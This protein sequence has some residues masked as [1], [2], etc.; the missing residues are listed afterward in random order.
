[1]IGYGPPGDWGQLPTHGD[2]DHERRAAEEYAGRRRVR[3]RMGLVA[4]VVIVIAAT[5]VV[6]LLVTHP[7]RHG[8]LIYRIEPSKG[9]LK[10]ALTDDRSGKHT[11]WVTLRNARGKLMRYG[12]TAFRDGSRGGSQTTS[13]VAP[14]AAGTYIYAV[15]DIAGIHY[16][17]GDADGPARDRIASGLVKVP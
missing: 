4:L 5:A 13:S 2:E 10:V 17:T 14:E 11:T 15:Y 12:F 8:A 1:M 6:L 16:S 3:R 7:G 9:H